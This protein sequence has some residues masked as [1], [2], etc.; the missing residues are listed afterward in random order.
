MKTK[1]IL[2]VGILFLL[3][4]CIVKSLY[5][6]YTLD[7]I[8]F[9]KQF[10]GR[11]ID[12]DDGEWEV[13]SVKEI[14]LKDAKVNSPTELDEVDSKEYQ[15]YKE[16]YY[17][18]YI[19]K[20]KESIFLGMPFKINDQLFIDFTPIELDLGGDLN[21]LLEAHLVMTHSLVKFDIINKEEISIKWFDEDKIEGLFD[22]NKI[23]IRHEKIGLEYGTYLLTASS[24]ELQKFI[25]KYMASKD[26]E[27]W[28]TD[29]DFNLKR[30]NA[31]S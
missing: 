20:G 8:S 6:F 17:I 28:K 9:E 10:V 23:K 2:L 15:K 14:L 5:P 18:K 25:K 12:Y 7:T 16:A 19:K 29:F 26:K 13:L 4:S 22:Q 27:K 31:K 24:E 30:V 11:W 3:N 1:T 21:N